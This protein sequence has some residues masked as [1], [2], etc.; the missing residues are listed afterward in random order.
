MSED[1]REVVRRF[2]EDFTNAHRLE[3]AEELLAE[4][5]TIRTSTGARL[6]GRDQVLE[7]LGRL[8]ESFP[9]FRHAI[10]EL[11]A[12][13]DRVF[14]RVTNTGTHLGAFR[15][16]EPTGARVE[17]PAAGWFRVRDGR[18]VDGWTVADTAEIWRAIGKL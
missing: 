18:I 10:D 8:H 15:G 6:Q 3:L 5:V 11:V 12:V 14:S 13:G 9:D 17:Y 4:D 16:V 2:Y 7:F 1:N